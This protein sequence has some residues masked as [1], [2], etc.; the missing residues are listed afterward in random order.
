M[1]R[2]LCALTAALVCL[3][4]T[5]AALAATPCAE[6]G[7]SY[8]TGTVTLHKDWAAAKAASGASA[9]AA[10]TK[11]LVFK[12]GLQ[13][14][15]LVP[16]GDGAFW[17]V[18]DLGLANPKGQF[19]D[20]AKDCKAGAEARVRVLGGKVVQITY[21]VM[22]AN[23][24]TEDNECI[25]ART[26]TSDTIIDAKTGAVVSLVGVDVPG[27]LDEEVYTRSS[28]TGDRLRV[29]YVD[30]VPETRT[31]SLKAINAC[32]LPHDTTA[33]KAATIW[34]KRARAAQAK[35]DYAG[36]RELFRLAIEQDGKSAA[37]HS[38]AGYNE[39]LGGEYYKADSLLTDALKLKP[40]ARIASQ[41]HYNLGVNKLN[42][43]A[44]IK[45]P[46]YKK[47][48]CARAAKHFEQANALR[49]SKAAA[50]KLAIAKTC[51]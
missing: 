33:A 28:L 43:S 39:V 14:A 24:M 26:S 9:K 19:E 11:P 5:S 20:E 10:L 22:D 35:K 50:S 18:R 23:R 38:E 46:D 47:Q 3:L 48:E 6:V 2:H 36:A 34:L 29:R 41:I 13:F 7:T 25:G 21:A 32:T 4:P 49:P 42:Y 30:D 45:V 16:R 44:K 12:K 40:D 17:E 1:T 51:P 27:P 31:L 15:V 37:L 8:P